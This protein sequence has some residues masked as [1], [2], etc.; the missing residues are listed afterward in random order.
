MK[1]LLFFVQKLRALAKIKVKNA[2]CHNILKEVIACALKASV[3]KA[4]Q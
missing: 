4:L 1:S 3:Q 2:C